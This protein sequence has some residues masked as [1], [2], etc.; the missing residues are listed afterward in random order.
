MHGAELDV[1]Q[2]D[3]CDSPTPGGGEQLVEVL[4][5]A[6]IDDVQNRVGLPGFHAVLDR[7][8]VGRGVEERAVLFLH[9]HRRLEAF[10]EDAHRPLA[11]LGQSLRSQVFDDAGQPVVIKALA[12]FVIELDVQPAIDAGDLVAA[13][14]QEL[15]PEAQVLGIAGVELGGFGEHGLVDVGMLG[16]ELR[17]AADR[18]RRRRFSSRATATSSASS[19]AL[20]CALASACAAFL[21][22]ALSPV[23]GCDFQPFDFGLPLGQP[24]LAARARPC[25]A[26]AV[27]DQPVDEL[28][29]PAELGDGVGCDRRRRS[30]KC[31]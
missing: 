24:L 4:A 20:S 1:L 28:V 27:I 9:D 26:F 14:G 13:V 25:T 31:L 18:L 21:S 11:V 30:T 12:V 8:Q 22:A 5:L 23:L 16:G 7:R 6:M 3:V 19:L 2:F 15:V 29:E 17:R 10:E